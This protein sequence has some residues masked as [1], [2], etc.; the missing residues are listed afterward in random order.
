MSRVAATVAKTSRL[1]DCFTGSR[2]PELQLQVI[3]CLARELG[4][5]AAKLMPRLVEPARDS[6]FG[7][8]GCVVVRENPRRTLDQVRR[9]QDRRLAPQRGAG[10]I[11][12]PAG[13]RRHDDCDFVLLLRDERPAREG[14]QQ[15]KDSN[16]SNTH[17]RPSCGTAHPPTCHVQALMRAAARASRHSSSADRI[18]GNAMSSSDTSSG[19]TQTIPSTSSS[20]CARAGS[21]ARATKNMSMTG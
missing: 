14:G 20:A 16:P 19:L 6:R 18:D 21:M 7:R 8:R 15:H 9:R 2:Y 13:H 1:P 5:A 12:C 11:R 17:G 3:R 4:R 10:K